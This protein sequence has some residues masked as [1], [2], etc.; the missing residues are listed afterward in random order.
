MISAKRKKPPK[1]LDRIEIHSGGVIEQHYTSEEYEP[2]I[3]HTGPRKRGATRAQQQQGAQIDGATV[4]RI[5]T[6]GRRIVEPVEAEPEEH[7]EIHPQ[8]GI[9]EQHFANGN[10]RSYT[11]G[12]KLRGATKAREVHGAPSASPGDGIS[13]TRTTEADPLARRKQATSW[14]ADVPVWQKRGWFKPGFTQG[15]RLKGAKLFTKGKE[16]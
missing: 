14:V 5:Q 8:S 6:T 10:S 1:V 4:S 13:A 2:Q 9:V 3:I 15:P 11:I 16:R 7:L 12:P